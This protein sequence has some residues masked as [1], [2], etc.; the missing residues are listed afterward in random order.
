MKKMMALALVLVMLLGCA[1][2]ALAE[3]AWSWSPNQPYAG[4]PPINL[5]EQLG[6]MMFYPNQAMPA[7]GLCD[8]LMIY[9]PR[10]DVEAGE[11]QLTILTGD[12]TEVWQTPMN[13]GAVVQMRKITPDELAGLLW[14]GGVCFEIALPRTLTLGETYT[15]SM[16]EGCIVAGRVTNA[17]IGGADMW[18]FDVAGDYGLSAIEYRRN[19]DGMV[20]D[21]QPGDEVRFELVLGGTAVAAALYSHGATVDFLTS[22]FTE[23]GEVVGTVTGESPAWGVLFFDGEGSIINQADF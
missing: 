19:G 23:S 4:Q 10:E 20:T 14:N 6:Y 2:A 12:G 21:P 11:G 1:Q 13:D 16:E 22:Y 9:L 3:E 18:G 7:Q 5:T 8:K 15:V 17:Q